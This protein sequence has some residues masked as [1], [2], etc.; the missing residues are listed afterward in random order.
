MKTDARPKGFY[1][2]YLE[3]LCA[4]REAAGQHDDDDEAYWQEWRRQHGVTPTNRDEEN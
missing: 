1:L 3:R 4:K 2:A